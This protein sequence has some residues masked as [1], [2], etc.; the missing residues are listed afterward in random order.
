MSTDGRFVAGQAKTP[1]SGRKPGSTNKRKTIDVAAILE[2]RDEDLV[3]DL[4]TDIRDMTDPVERATAR[5][6]LLEYVAPRRK[7]IEMSGHLGTEAAPITEENV[8]DVLRRARL[9]AVRGSAGAG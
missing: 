6:K 8:D 7:A 9:R 4:L 5:L 2:E 1:G 3:G